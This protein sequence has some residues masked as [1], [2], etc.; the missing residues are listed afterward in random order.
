MNAPVT[1][2]LSSAILEALFSP[3]QIDGNFV[4]AQA[5][6]LRSMGQ[7]RPLVLFAFAP[8]SAGTFFR[9]AAIDAIN[10]Q[11]MRFVHAEGGRDATLYLPTL[12]AY[13]SGSYTANIGVTHVHMQANTANRHMLDI[14]DLRPVIMLR[15]IPDMLSSLWRFLEQDNPLGFSFLKPMDFA[16]KTDA[17]KADLMIDVIGPW[18]VQYFAGWKRYAEE[19]PERVCVLDFSWLQDDP[20]DA[21][22]QALAHARAPSSYEMCQTAIASTR[23][24]GASFRCNPGQPV[25]DFGAERLAR[26]SR[27]YGL[28]SELESWRG[29][30]LPHTA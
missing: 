20:A 3:P 1:S 25:Q 2:T 23:A 21:L 28:Y 13:F 24:Q 17:E 9:T 7:R 27:L 8:R 14:F 5:E 29:E 6:F 19:Q 11:L 18:Y 12:L 16:S 22:E 15:S 26:L 10:G 30:L 4:A